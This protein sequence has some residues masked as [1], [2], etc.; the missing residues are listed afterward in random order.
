[1]VLT[2]SSAVITACAR[3][4]LTYGDHHLSTDNSGHLP[5]NTAPVNSGRPK[6]HRQVLTPVLAEAVPEH[7]YRPRGVRRV[8]RPSGAADGARRT[9]TWP[10][11]ARHDRRPGGGWKAAPWPGSSSSPSPALLED[12]TSAGLED[13]L[14]LRMLEEEAG[15]QPMQEAEPSSVRSSTSARMMKI[16]EAE[17]GAEAAAR[18]ASPHHKTGDHPYG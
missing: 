16:L 11:R 10:A 2:V 5:S 14:P 12:V 7:E 17:G 8:E 18:F 6:A 13:A 4:S 9:W 1:V 15:H 3:G